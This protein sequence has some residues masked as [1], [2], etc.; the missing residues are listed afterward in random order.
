MPSWAPRGDESWILPI[1]FGELKAVDP[2]SDQEKKLSRAQAHLARAERRAKLAQTIVKRWKR[3]VVAA[4]R[5]L[6]RRQMKA[7]A[8][9]SK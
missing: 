6:D 3:R 7:A 1:P 4:E 5:A 9:E 8:G 2:V